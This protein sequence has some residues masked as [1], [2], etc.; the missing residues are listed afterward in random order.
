[1]KY[2]QLLIILIFICFI[3]VSCENKDNTSYELT[4]ENT[5][6]GISESSQHQS[7]VIAYNQTAESELPVTESYIVSSS[8]K[9]ENSIDLQSGI[10]SETATENSNAIILLETIVER[11]KRGMVINSDYVVGLL[12][13][14]M[15]PEKIHG[16]DYIDDNGYFVYEQEY[17]A[18]D[19]NAR[20]GTTG[21]ARSFLPELSIIKKDDVQ[22]ILGEHDYISQTDYNETVLGYILNDDYRIKF[23]FDDAS[24]LHHYNVYKP[25]AY[26]NPMGSNKPRLW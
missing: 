23:V 24:N 2:K 17:L 8:E 4:Y 22:L 20:S 12:S 26:R 1:M 21:E 3:F 18:F 15:I 6:S 10:I 25:D 5:D 9:I 7:S 14:G 16:D 19:H 11:G 13:H